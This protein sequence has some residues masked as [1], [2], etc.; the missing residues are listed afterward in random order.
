MNQGKKLEIFLVEDN[1]GDIRLTQEILKQSALP[2]S[3]RIAYDGEEALHYLEK[4]DDSLDSDPLPHLILLDLNLPKKSGIEV[5]ST[6][7]ANTTLKHIPVVV[8]TS[9]E[10]EQD[11]KVCYNMH[12]NSYV[13]KPVDFDQYYDVITNIHR[14]WS[15]VV[16]LAE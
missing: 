1:P 13:T 2:S 5:L 7:K 16:E 10:S 12:A 11:I 9:S 8:L 4:L 15:E 6:L 3:L 14:F